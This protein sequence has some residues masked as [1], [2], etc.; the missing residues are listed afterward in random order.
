VYQDRALTCR[1]CT[2]EFIFSAGEQTF[3]AT[4]GLTN[5]PQR[6]PGCR[7]AAKRARSTDGPREF[8]AAICGACGGQA[9]V[10]P[11]GTIALSTA[12]LFHKAPVPSPRRHRHA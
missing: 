11:C 1:D 9:V 8:H 12:A 10:P 6:C 5:D 3:Y 2:E 7:A 4:K